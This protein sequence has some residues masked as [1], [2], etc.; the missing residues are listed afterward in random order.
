MKSHTYK[1]ERIIPS[2]RYNGHWCIW[3]DDVNVPPTKWFLA[4]LH[5]S[6]RVSL[7]REVH[8]VRSELSWGGH[9]GGRQELWGPQWWASQ[10]SVTFPDRWQS[11]G[12]GYLVQKYSVAD[13][14]GQDGHRLVDWVA[15]QERLDCRAVLPH[16]G[17]IEPGVECRRWAFFWGLGALCSQLPAASPGYVSHEQ[18]VR[19]GTWKFRGHLWQNWFVGVSLW[20]LQFHSR[21]VLEQWEL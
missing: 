15:P 1:R 4:F 11:R 16:D 18:N 17:L 12:G 3:E 10:S 6:L 20:S 21:I 7:G 8:G 14:V 5:V 2:Y 19:V 13:G 9:G